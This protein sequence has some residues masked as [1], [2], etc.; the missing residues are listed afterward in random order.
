MGNRGE[1][2]GVNINLEFMINIESEN[3]IMKNYA[4]DFGHKFEGNLAIALKNNLSNVV[5]EVELATPYEDQ[6]EKVDLW[7]KFRYIEDPVAVQVTFTSSEKRRAEKEVNIKE[8]FLV[9]KENR[10]N[11]LIK[12]RGNCYRV[13]AAY[14]KVKAKTG[15]ID[16]RMQA[17]TLRQIL[18]G[19]PNQ[20][21]AFYMKAIE[22]GMKKSG[23]RVLGRG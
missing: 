18:A 5:E 22:E 4:E 21:R 7:V 23:K 11:A 15:V 14:E 16:Q 6:I 13:L 20:S 10:P 12:A 8:K 2:E 3:K 19:L 1:A 17:D 9:K